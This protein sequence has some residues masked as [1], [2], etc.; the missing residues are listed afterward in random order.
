MSTVPTLSIESTDVTSELLDKTLRWALN[1]LDFTLYDP[2]TVPA[3]GDT[4]DV[5]DPDWSGIVVNVEETP[6]VRGNVLFVKVTA[7]NTDT[8]GASAAP[9]G[10]SDTPN[11]TTTFGY[12][13][14]SRASVR[15]DTG[16]SVRVGLECWEEGLLPGQ[17]VALTSALLGYSADDFTMVDCQVGW[18][19]DDHAVY[20]IHLGDAIVTM[21]VWLN[22]AEA[23]IL[24]DRPYQDHRR[25]GHHAE[26][27]RQRRDG[28]PSSPPRLITADKMLVGDIGPTCLTNPGLRDG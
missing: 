4:V 25:R 14:I 26:A 11:G 16:D 21:K 5:T 1:T 22:S 6:D 7:T 3:L 12:R 23:G 8:A 15:T 2:S 18:D 28:R 9:F 17:T 20:K 13:N 24:P 19:R 27:R 10:L